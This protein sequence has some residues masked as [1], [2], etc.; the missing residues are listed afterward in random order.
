VQ[1]IVFPWCELAVL[2]LRS[3]ATR[4]GWSVPVA[5]AFEA[6]AR[7]TGSAGGGRL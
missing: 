5:P 6:D 1:G 4:R 2:F 7:A 3:T